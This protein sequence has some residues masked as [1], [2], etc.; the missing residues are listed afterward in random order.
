VTAFRLALLIVACLLIAGGACVFILGPP[1]IAARYVGIELLSSGI[2]IL[3][4]TLFERWR[5]RNKR[6]A[7]DGNWQRTDE[8]FVD[9][10]SGKQVEVWYDP[11]TGERRYQDLG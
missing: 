8:R 10:E 6:A 9:P 3:L 11:R 5:Y 2:V 1:S 4:G 7:A